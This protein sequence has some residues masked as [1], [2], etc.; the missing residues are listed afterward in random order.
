M[1][2]KISWLI[3]IS[4]LS[5]F[6][7]PVSA[8]NALTVPN[9]YSCN[10]GDTNAG[11]TSPTCTHT[12]TYAASVSYSAPTS[13]TSYSLPSAWYLGF[14]SSS[15]AVIASPSST[16]G[17]YSTNGSTWTAFTRSVSSSPLNGVACAS[18]YIIVY[19]SNSYD[20]ST[21]GHTWSAK[22]LPSGVTPNNVSCANNSLVITTGSLAKYYVSSDGINWTSYNTPDSA[23]YSG[24]T[25]FDGYYELFSNSSVWYASSL[26]GTFT[27]SSSSIVASASYFASDSS[28]VFA[29]NSG[30]CYKSSDGVTWTSVSPSSNTLG[31]A[32]GDGYFYINSY[33]SSSVGQYYFQGSN[34]SVVGTYDSGT[35]FLQG[36]YFNHHFY[37]GKTGTA[38]L[39]SLLGGVTYTCTSG[40]TLFLSTCTNTTTYAGTLITT[41]PTS[42][43]PIYSCPSG[44]ASSGS[45]SS[46]ICTAVSPSYPASS[47]NTCSSGDSLISAPSTPQGQLCK[48]PSSTSAPSSNTVF[49]CNTGDT[50]NTTT[51]MCVTTQSS[52]IS[53][54]N[55]VY[56]C[57]S[58]VAVLNLTTHMCVISSSSYTATTTNT[59]T[60][61]SG[62]GDLN[63]HPSYGTTCITSGSTSYVPATQSY[64]CPSGY[65]LQTGVFVTCVKASYNYA[66]LVKTT[67][68]CTGVSFYNSTTCIEYGFTFPATIS[69][70]TYCNSGDTMSS[71]PYYT[72][73]HPV[74]YQ[75][76]TS[77]TNSYTCPSPSNSTNVVSLSNGV[78]MGQCVTPSS[79][80]TATAVPTYSCND[81]ADVLNLSSHICTRAGSSV[82]ANSVTSYT[83]PAGGVL[84]VDQLHCLQTANTYPE[85]S[86]VS[87][88]CSGG[89]AL[90][91]GTTCVQSGTTYSPTVVF[92]C[93]GS[94]SLVGDSCFISST[95]TAYVLTYAGSCPLNFILNP[96]TG[97]CNLA[98]SGTVSATTQG[99]Y[100]C[101][102]VSS[103][104]SDSISYTSAYDATSTDGQGSYISCQLENLPSSSLLTGLYICTSNDY[105]TGSSL[106]YT[107][108]LDLTGVSVNA[109]ISCTYTGDLPIDLSQSDVPV[110]VEPT[111]PD[112][113]PCSLV[114][115][116]FLDYVN[117]LVANS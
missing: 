48:S 28:L 106:T 14:A 1:K 11:G 115:T 20:Y 9:V 117:C 105:T 107:S 52:Y 2:K 6:L 108:T 43:V 68:L 74:D 110:Y 86:T 29:C 67:Y 61:P 91:N 84:S 71:G 114:D 81:I 83:C 37:Y 58:S 49:G 33:S 104:T 60:C 34:G 35:Y 18:V 40:D 92:S 38:I 90:T 75:N 96:Q 47:S 88:T 25:Y 94:D 116:G 15:T 80:Y 69:T 66:P 111:S 10:T 5:S 24:S 7:L 64:T 41:A 31:V 8:S 73:T 56:S 103:S 76:V 89:Y 44:Y 78:L 100:S 77:T 55:P 82:S 3:G 54:P 87:Y 42:Y 45:G 79:S 12:T 16:T 63:G 19:S 95:T 57:A 22:S 50:L 65:T 46:T 4:L 53:T 36:F 62:G 59:Y 72:C 109:N 85:L 99:Q 113:D 98:S 51:G 112:L 30:G 32:Y 102:L 21:D 26:T 97:A 93:S 13:S 70:S 23:T 101:T 39:Y 17:E 27:K